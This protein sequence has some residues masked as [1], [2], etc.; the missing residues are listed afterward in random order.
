MSQQL[1][2]QPP[3]KIQKIANE[4]LNKDDP[5]FKPIVWIDCEV[6]MDKMNEWCIEHHGGVSKY[7][8]NLC[9]LSTNI[10]QSGLTQK[11]LE[12]NKT[13]SQV[14]DELYQYVSKYTNQ[15]S[16]VLA[17]NSVHMD[18]AF[19]MREMPNVLEHLHY[20]LIDVSTI[21]EIGK[22][23]NMDLISKLPKKKGGTYCKIRYLGVNCSVEMV[24]R[25]LFSAAR[26]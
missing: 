26:T 15:R 16:A 25:P 9:L 2:E 17:G 13:L 7:F 20:R 6:I 24:S 14:E 3:A 22:R 1:S 12:S 18:R 4:N 5:N 21:T 23:H 11:V 10:P 8:L 19:M